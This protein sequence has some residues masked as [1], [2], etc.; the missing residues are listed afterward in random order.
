MKL[1]PGALNGAKHTEM[2]EVYNGEDKYEIEVRPLRHSEASVI[3]AML[4]KGFKMKT[5]GTGLNTNTVDVD[6]EKTVQ[7]QFE[8]QLESAARGTV[9]AGWTAEVIDA[10]WLPE[11]IKVVGDHV[12]KISGIGNKKEDQDEVEQFRQV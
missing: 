11:W 5:G 1:L 7:A 2:V 12:M 9:D 4:S 3:Q 8:A 6:M 10:E